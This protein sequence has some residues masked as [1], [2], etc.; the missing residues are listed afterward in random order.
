[1]ISNLSE[2]L[3]DIANNK[4][5]KCNNTFSTYQ[6]EFKQANYPQLALCSMFLYDDQHR[7]QT[8]RQVMFEYHKRAE[9]IC[10]KMF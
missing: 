6:L 1:M 3:F 4:Q 2:Y 9:F 10:F 8:W 7:S 5:N